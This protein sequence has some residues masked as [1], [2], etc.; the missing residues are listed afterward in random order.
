M[1]NFRAKCV[2]VRDLARERFAEVDLE[3][4]RKVAPEHS[5][6]LDIRPAGPRHEVVLHALLDIVTRE[7]IENMRDEI[8]NPETND[9][10]PPKDQQTQNQDD[11]GTEDQQTQNQDD[12]G[13]EEQQTQNQD[14]DGTTD[15]EGEN[16]G[17]KDQVNDFSGQ[18]D[19]LNGRMD[20]LEGQVSEI[21]DD[22]KEQK[23][24]GKRPA[25][26]KKKTN[27]R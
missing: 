25:K 8:M 2:H 23:K 14:G 17:L 4:L 9:A 22:L 16:L 1:Y 13:T 19:D 10:E 3:I 18:T 20:D 7:A 12:G 11:G 21:A 24:S 15:V 27:T 5:E 26:S 6:S